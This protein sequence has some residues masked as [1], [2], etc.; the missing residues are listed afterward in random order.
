[1]HVPLEFRKYP[2]SSY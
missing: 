2:T 1:M